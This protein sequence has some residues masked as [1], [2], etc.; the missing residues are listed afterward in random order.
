[1]IRGIYIAASGMLAE[2]LRNDAIANNLANANSAGY[3]K[4]I[5]VTK[6]FADMM[7]ERINDGPVEPVG[8]LGSGTMVD[9]IATDHSAGSIRSTGNDLDFALQGDGYFVVQT[10]AGTRYTRDG[11]FTLDAQGE[12]VTADGY[13]VLGPNGPIRLSGGK[14]AVSPQGRIQ[15]D[16][17]DAG[18]L[19]I[20]DFANKKQLSKEGNSLFVAANGAVPQASNATVHQ[21]FLEGS[22][23]NIVSEMVNMISGYRTYEV[24]SK[25][26]QAQD[27]LLDKAV[28]EVGKVG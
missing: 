17:L 16:G 23:V 1:M 12:L 28:N 26:V 15:V 10:P 27:Q 11:S 3:K 14:V 22:N 8:P 2:S 9:E 18:Q 24:D 4:D 13:Q 7:L 21:G 25:M 19:Q 5:T 6:N 20:V